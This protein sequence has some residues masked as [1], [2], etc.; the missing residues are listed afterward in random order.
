MAEKLGAI[1][2]RKGLIN[3]GQLDEALKAQMIYGGRL[4]TNLVELEYLS[5]ETLGAVLSEQTRYPL[6]AESEFEHVTSATLSTIPTALAEKH[7]AFP[8][9]V[10]GKRLRVAMASP[11]DFAAVDE[12]SFI[13]GLRVVPCIIPELR[14][15]FHLEKRYGIVRPE[16]YIKLDP[17]ATRTGA[18]ARAPGGAPVAQAAGSPGGPPAPRPATPTSPEKQSMFGGLQAGQFLSN[19][20]AEGGAEAGGQKEAPQKESP[21][22]AEREA[23]GGVSFGEFL[24]G[25]EDDPAQAPAPAAA[26]PVSA[27]APQAPM[28]G[29]PPGA[30]AAGPA[31]PGR[32]APPRGRPRPSRRPGPPRPPRPA[33]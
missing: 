28:Q 10:E 6:A 33:R 24:S 13:T 11:F 25:D 20:D 17:E 26:R 19:D 7:F 16:R 8:L 3:Q 14:L 1:L 22:G 31:R 27:P 29:R 12:I 5:I 21:L 4:G 30:P 18:G 15:Y 2:V 23:F 9:A 32:A